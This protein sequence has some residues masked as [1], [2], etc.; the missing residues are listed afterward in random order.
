M[1]CSSPS[2]IWNAILSRRNFR[3]E[4]IKGKT[5][6][7]SFTGLMS[8]KNKIGFHNHTNQN[9]SVRIFSSKLDIYLPMQWYILIEINLIYNIL[10]RNLLDLKRMSNT[11]KDLY[12][13]SKP[14][15]T[16]NQIQQLP[17]IWDQQWITW[18]AFLPNSKSVNSIWTVSRNVQN[19]M[20]HNPLTSGR[21]RFV[22]CCK[23]KCAKASSF[24][25]TTVNFV[26]KFQ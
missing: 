25:T 23:M 12:Y 24:A 9:F 4:K 19:E 16:K 10:H 1:S 13:L 22:Y 8:W 17:N 15:F 18:C 26:E 3:M 2:Q 11:W 7:R 20:V 6:K 5:S 14:M 21:N